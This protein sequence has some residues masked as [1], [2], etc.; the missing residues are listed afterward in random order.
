[1]ELKLKYLTILL[2]YISLTS[3]GCRNTPRLSEEEFDLVFKN[4]VAELESKRWDININLKGR[5]VYLELLPL[6]D[7]IIEELKNN[8]KVVRFRPD[9]LRYIS[10]YDTLFSAK[11][12]I[13]SFLT[14]NYHSFK[15]NSLTKIQELIFIDKFTDLI[16]WN[17]CFGDGYSE[18]VIQYIPNDTI[19]L[20][21]NTHY[22]IPIRMENNERNCG[23]FILS[24]TSQSI[25]ETKVS[26]DTYPASRK[27]QSIDFTVRGKYEGLNDIYSFKE[28]L[29]IR[30]IPKNFR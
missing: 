17:T 14:V 24:N 11:V 1:M 28:T 9:I 25:S 26:F 12:P 3:I 16:F 10:Q 6:I 29:H 13:D 7:G 21:E 18:S 15:S 4:Y 2:I 22:D 23:L 19:L 20:F 8:Q 5:S 30:L 27:Y